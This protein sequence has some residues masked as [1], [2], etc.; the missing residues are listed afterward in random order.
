MLPPTEIGCTCITSNQA[1][2]LAFAAPSSAEGKVYKKLSLPR[3]IGGLRFDIEPILHIL[4]RS[5][6]RNTICTHNRA[7]LDAFLQI[8]LNIHSSRVTMILFLINALVDRRCY[9]LAYCLTLFY[10]QSCVTLKVLVVFAVQF[11]GYHT[12][13]RVIHSGSRGQEVGGQIV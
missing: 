5:T 12:W 8:A 4:F 3:T 11:C 13:H 7:I 10:Y 6:C 1:T 9:N 2:S